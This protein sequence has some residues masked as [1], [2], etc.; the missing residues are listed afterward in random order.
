MNRLKKLVL[1][2]DKPV[3]PEFIKILTF[4]LHEIFRVQNRFGEAPQDPEAAHQLRVKIRACRSLLSFSKPLLDQQEYAIM[5]AQLRSIAQSFAHLREV[6]VLQSEWQELLKFYPELAG[7]VPGFLENLQTNRAAEAA[8]LSREVFEGAVVNRLFAVYCRLMNLSQSAGAVGQE[9]FAAIN[10]RDYTQDWL[11][12]WFKK[13][14]KACGRGIL[15][16]WQRC[17]ACGFALKNCVMW[18]IAWRLI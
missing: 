14:S 11:H 9:V 8:R 6:D 13:T 18:R 10:F 16:T 5:Q 7:P 1:R 15:L 3:L 17:I 4:Y 2:Q 12:K